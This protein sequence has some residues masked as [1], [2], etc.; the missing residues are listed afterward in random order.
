MTALLPDGRYDV[1]IVDAETKPGNTIAL[2]LAI[3]SGEHRGE[4]VTVDAS[5]LEVADPIDLLGFPATLTVADGAPS[6]TID[7]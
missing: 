3:A 5:G 7:R 4:M 1:M 6:V 2:D